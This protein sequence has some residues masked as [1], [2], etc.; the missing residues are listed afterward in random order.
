MTFLSPGESLYAKFKA[1]RLASGIIKYFVLSILCFI[2]FVIFLTGIIPITGYVAQFVPY[3]GLVV[4]FFAVGAILWGVGEYVREDINGIFAVTTFRIIVIKGIFRKH[5]DSVSYE[6]IV[7][8]K[9]DKTFTDRI[10]GLG[11]ISIT[12]ARG[13]EEIRLHG[14]RR[15]DEV[16]SAIYKFIAKEK[17]YGTMS[18]RKR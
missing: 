7:N 4:F 14:V 12:T 13:H 3:E 1:S 16:E 11:T 18:G 17:K 5:I 9:T 10:F 15:P 8:V 6:M 2:V